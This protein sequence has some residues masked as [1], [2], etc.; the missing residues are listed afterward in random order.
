MLANEKLAEMV[1]ELKTRR[2]DIYLKCEFDNMKTSDE[3]QRRKI[4]SLEEENKELK[5]QQ[6]KKNSGRKY[7]SRKNDPRITVHSSE[8]RKEYN[9]QVMYLKNHPDCQY[10]AP[11][12]WT[13]KKTNRK[14]ESASKDQSEED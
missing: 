5:E 12:K 14:S 11:R 7:I 13:K 10:I 2:P 6:E 3:V 9:R 1:A 8:D 4:K